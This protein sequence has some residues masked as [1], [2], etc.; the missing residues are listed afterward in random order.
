[1]QTGCDRQARIRIG[2]LAA[3][4]LLAFSALQARAQPAA[5][6]ILALSPAH[7]PE[8][9]RVEISGKNLAGASEVRFGG[10]QAV[11]AAVSSQKLVA[12]VPHQVPTSSFTVTTPQGRSS[13][14]RFV[15]SKDPRI[16]DEVSYRA[17]RLLHR[18]ALVQRGSGVSRLRT[19]GCRATNRRKWKL[20][21]L[22][23][24]A[25]STAGKLSS[26]MTVPGCREGF[27]AVSR[28]LART[29]MIPCRSPTIRQ[30]MP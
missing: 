5:P 13:P 29:H 21:G 14:F 2:R 1:M 25:G 28:G 7:G 10:S 30:T 3:A 4:V 6:E 16:P 12:I 22:G 8:G 27:T 18:P 11:F 20:A 15:V 24:P 19:H 23:C 9:T 17:T 26:M